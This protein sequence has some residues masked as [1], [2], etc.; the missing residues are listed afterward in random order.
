MHVTRVSTCILFLAGLMV[1]S[2]PGHAQSARVV[3]LGVGQTQTV[4]FSRGFQNVHVLNPAVADVVA[5]TNKS[6]TVVGVSPGDTELL[7]RSFGG[8]TL[9]VRVFISK[10]S[11]S[12]LFRAVRRFLG[13]ME[14]VHPRLFGDWVILDGRALTARD[15]GRVVQAKKLFGMKVKNF[16]GYR[17]SAVQEI[18][19]ILTKAG[20]TT[21][22]ATLIAGM[23]FLEGAVGSKTEMAK[24]NKVIQTLNLRVNNLVSI[25]KGRQVLVEVKFVEMQRSRHINFGLQLPAAITGMGSIIGNIPLY[26]AGGSSVNLQLQT[27]DSAMTV[28]LNTLFQTGKARLL[29]KPKLVCGSGEKAKFMVGGEV[30]IVH[31]AVG[32]F[33]VEYKPF[34]IMLNIEPVA[35]SRGNITAKL[36]AEVSEPDWTHAI[37]G[38]PAFITRRVET[39]VTMK[40]GSTLI[41]SGL[42][43]H[44]M[45]KSIFKFPLLGHIPIL[46]ELFKS[47]DYQREKTSLVVFITTRTI[48]ASHPWVVKQH[49]LVNRQMWHFSNETSW[50]LFE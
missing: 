37:K 36:K 3:R 22:R 7:V 18:N 21:V 15:Y 13:P 27:P 12:K 19:Q 6:V 30:P 1:W 43:S 35:D 5:Y 40:E 39:K 16:A 45:S 42:Y 9:R 48:T 26:P 17:P 31:E 49:R 11:V 33:N 38:Y 29:A 28:Q 14:G 4:S 46:G 44:K 8:R 25:G 41:L 20:L 50:E 24:V 10:T 47:R 23:V 2:R 34:G 32:S